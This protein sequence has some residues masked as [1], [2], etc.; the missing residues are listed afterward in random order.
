MVDRCGADGKTFGASLFDHPKQGK[1]GEAALLLR[2]TST[3]IRMNSGEPDLLDVL[4]QR[5]AILIL[6]DCYGGCDGG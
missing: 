2:V 3:Y 5:S 6:M 4:R 1:L